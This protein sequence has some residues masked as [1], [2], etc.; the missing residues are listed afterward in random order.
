MKGIILA[1][2]KGTR[3]RPL[4]YSRPKGLI[5]VVNKPFLEYQVELLR[6]HNICN[7]ILS[8]NYLADEFVRHFQDG[9]A[10]G[11]SIQYAVEKV[12]LGTGG[13]IKNCEPHLGKDRVIVLNGDVLTDA[14]LGAIVSDHEASGSAVTLTTTATDNPTAYGLVLTDSAG[15]V[16]AFLEKPGWDEIAAD[17][18]NAGIYVL[19]PSVVAA[20]PAGR[21]VSFERDIIPRLL[22]ERAAVRA[23]LTRGY[24]Q[25]IG[26]LRNYLKAHIDILDGRID[27][28]IPGRRIGRGVSCGR[29]VRV[30]R[31]A[32]LAAPVALGNDVNVGP[33]AQI[34][35]WGVLG[36]GCV[37]GED[38]HVSESVVHG[39]VSVGRGSR[40][41]RCVI[42]SGVKIAE[43]CRL[44]SMVVAAGSVVCQGTRVDVELSASGAS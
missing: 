14:D 30:H 19:E 39:G 26:T 15:R 42:A 37:I 3:L 10:W 22:G 1:G 32:R 31:T 8:L 23:Y 4:T 44:D 40:L 2:G 27:V 16:T 11:V 36:D 7:I 21:E 13:A 28:M 17:T 25:D 12:P 9:A 5:P 35:P 29:N 43:G 41:S 18:V 24:W 6:A 38:A 33:R 34:G 20:L